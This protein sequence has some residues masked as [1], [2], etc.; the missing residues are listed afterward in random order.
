MSLEETFKQGDVSLE[1][2]FKQGNI[3]SGKLSEMPVVE[4]VVQG[5]PS[6]PYAQES[7]SFTGT[8]IDVTPEGEVKTIKIEDVG[9]LEHD[10][11]ISIGDIVGLDTCDG[12]RDYSFKS[13]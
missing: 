4:L 2:T 12:I 9:A 8:V 1:G 6:T 3:I 13:S 10:T 11:R 7:I 5:K